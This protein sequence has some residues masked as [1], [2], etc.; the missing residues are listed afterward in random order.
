MWLRTQ[1]AASVPLAFGAGEGHGT[2]AGRVHDATAQRI[3]LWEIVVP[4]T[5]RGRGSPFQMPA[6]LAVG[7]G[8]ES[9]R[10]DGSHQR[11]PRPDC[12]G[13]GSPALARRKADQ[14]RLQLERSMTERR[15][16]S[17]DPQVK[18]KPELE[19]SRT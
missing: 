3:S 12:S 9:D 16:L 6:R 10:A 13:I 17:N 1:R 8:P 7:L 18:R 4:A 14:L 5:R 19:L 2:L 11:S 15:A